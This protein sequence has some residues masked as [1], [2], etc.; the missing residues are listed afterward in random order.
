MARPGQFTKLFGPSGGDYAMRPQVL[1]VDPRPRDRAEGYVSVNFASMRN[2]LPELVT[3]LMN[4]VLRSLG[5]GV[6]SDAFRED[7][8]IIAS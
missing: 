4:L 5:H 7:V 2:D 6:L 1:D 8:R 3:N